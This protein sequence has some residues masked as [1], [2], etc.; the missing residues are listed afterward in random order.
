MGNLSLELSCLKNLRSRFARFCLRHRNKGIP[1]LMLFV[2]LGA[3]IVSLLCAV[4][5][6]QL[7]AMLV[8]DRD[9]IL[10]GQVWRLITYPFTMGSSFSFFTLIALYCYYSLGRAIENTWGTFRFNLFYFPVCC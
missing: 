3:G 6:P 8:F 5:N 2:V 1:N 7:Y 4:G 9:A 10:S